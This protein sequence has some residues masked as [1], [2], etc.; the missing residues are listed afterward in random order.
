MG[1]TFRQGFKGVSKVFKGK[2]G[3]QH[4]IGQENI[5]DETDVQMDSPSAA[6][7][8]ARSQ[9]AVCSSR[10]DVLEEGR[11]TS[12]VSIASAGSK[13]KVRSRPVNID[14]ELARDASGDDAENIDA[15]SC[16]AVLEQVFNDSNNIGPAHQDRRRSTASVDTLAEGEGPRALSEVMPNWFLEPN[17]MNLWH[18]FEEK[19]ALDY[20]KPNPQHI[21]RCEVK[22]SGTA[23]KIIKSTYTSPGGETLLITVP[24]DEFH[25]A[26]ARLNVQAILVEITYITKNFMCQE[27]KRAFSWLPEETL[28]FIKLRK[29]I[30][31][32]HSQYK[33]N[34]T[35]GL[36]PPS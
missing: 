25:A 15:A 16:R 35:K 27:I 4:D 14:Q 32:Y 12:P 30:Q 6:I 9:P 1:D 22:I 23:K 17:R 8:A 11:A 7:A 13:R 36:P 29:T 19:I 21:R 3:S 24:S 2:K 10:R 26:T 5:G 18:L 20:F 34:T 33:Y 31:G 28:Y